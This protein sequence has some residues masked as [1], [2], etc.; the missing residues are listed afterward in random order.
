MRDWKV[1][2]Q[3]TLDQ[4]FFPLIFDS[5][6]HGIFTINSEGKIT[7]FN[8]MA[9]ELT[10][11]QREEVIGK[12]CASIFQT[13]MCRR[14]CP[15]KGSIRTGER[16]ETNEVTMITRSG[17]K[18][19]VAIETAALINDEGHIIGGVEMFHDLRLVA[20]LRK[21]LHSRYVFEDIVSKNHRMHEIFKLLPLVANSHST[22]LITGESGTG[23]ELIARAIHNLGARNKGPFA[24]V[25]CGAIPDNLLESELFGYKKGAFTD[26]KT[27]KPGRFAAA[28]GG[29]LLLDEIGDVSK[30]MQVK[31][32]RVIQE[33]E[34][35]PLGSNHSEKADV[36][37]LAATNRDLA[38]DV[39]RGSFRQDLYYRLNVVQI[40]LPPLRDRR[41][42]I[43]LLVQHFINRFNILQKRRI[44]R[45]SERAMSAL[46]GYTYPGNIRELENCIEHAFVVCTN[47]TIQRSDLPLHLSRSLDE[48]KARAEP[49]V[50]PLESAEAETIRRTLEQNEF[51]R[52]LT[53]K[54]L[55]ISRNTLWRKMRKY[56]IAVP[57]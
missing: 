14:H 49:A 6:S 9:E 22:V 45:C 30:S 13:D 4:R 57:S 20:E 27:D 36:R 5:I 35:V 44:Q 37:V 21:Q 16:G 52:L 34:Y 10:E 50:L 18:L 55:G 42:D 46:M 53:A 28:R 31:L 23:K 41:E 3:T 32:L 11:Y 43:P 48:G 2:M 26:A 33:R 40:E 15:L 29:T 54:Q 19:P 7:S 17:R 25:N 12:A 47:H 1:P 51:S 24:A 8:R 38:R 39:E 56:E